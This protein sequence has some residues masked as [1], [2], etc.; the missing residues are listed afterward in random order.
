MGM[1]PF[2]MEGPIYHLVDM[3]SGS[4]VGTENIVLA[5]YVY[6]FW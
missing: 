1:D 2:I 4:I 3:H 6:K 5:Y